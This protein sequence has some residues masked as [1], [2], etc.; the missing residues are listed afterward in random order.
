MSSPWSSG[1]VWPSLWL[2][3]KLFIL[4]AHSAPARQSLV[5]L[6]VWISLPAN[7]LFR[8]LFQCLQKRLPG[9]FPGG[10]VVKN[11]QYRGHGPVGPT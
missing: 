6:A 5:S 11:P 9:D 1:P 8:S 10:S 4:L 3:T 7:G 2:L